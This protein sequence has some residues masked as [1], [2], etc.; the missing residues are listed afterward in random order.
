VTVLAWLAGELRACLVLA[1]VAEARRKILARVEVDANGCWLWQGAKGA[2]GR[3]GHLRLFGRHVY[4]H[5]LAYVAWGGT[6]T[7]SRY[8]ALHSCDVTLCCNPAHITRGSEGENLKEAWDRARRTY[9]GCA[10]PR[11]DPECPF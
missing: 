8:H 1:V 11:I 2:Q 5:R 10:V 6:F 4:A 9:A 3:Y 7:R